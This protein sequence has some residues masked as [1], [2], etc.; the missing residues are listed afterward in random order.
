MDI[1]RR[2]I[3]PCAVFLPDG[4]RAIPDT[5]ALLRRLVLFDTYILQTIRFKEF[6]P[7]TRSL[8]LDNVLLLLGSEA[9]K[10]ELD[11]RE[12]A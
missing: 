7:L 9:L 3:A 5:T 10:L 11:H 6:I 4:Q 1:Q 2:L 8:G 12:N